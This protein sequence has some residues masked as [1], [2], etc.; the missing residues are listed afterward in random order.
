MKYKY[1]THS[2][3]IWGKASKYFSTKKQAQAEMK[4]L[5]RKHPKTRFKL[6]GE[7]EK[8]RHR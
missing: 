3:I 2:Q 4:R 7:G 8:H 6:G 1:E 5:K